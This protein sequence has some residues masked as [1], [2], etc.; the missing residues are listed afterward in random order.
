MKNKYHRDN[1]KLSEIRD[2]I[3]KVEDKLNQQDARVGL[4]TGKGRPDAPVTESVDEILSQTG[5][6]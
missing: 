6:K 1:T 3:E 5:G 4:D 2:G